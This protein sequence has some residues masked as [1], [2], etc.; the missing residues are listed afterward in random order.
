MEKSQCLKLGP[1]SGCLSRLG[2]SCSLRYLS[3]F[4][5]YVKI[6]HHTLIFFPLL[7]VFSTLV[8]HAY[9][10]D[11]FFLFVL[12][13]TVFLS[14]KEKCPGTSSSL[15]QQL[16]FP[17]RLYTR[18]HTHT[19]A[20]CIRVHVCLLQASS[21]FS[22]ALFITRLCNHFCCS[23]VKCLKTAVWWRASTEQQQLLHD[24]P[25]W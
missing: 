17:L 22:Y 2:E 12:H 13:T 5:A 20:Q 10:M 14:M 3:Y 4:I 1:W 18:T 9:T 15:A 23:S 24:L 16:I 19:L 25:Y 21:F 6:P 7:I 8:C 11:L